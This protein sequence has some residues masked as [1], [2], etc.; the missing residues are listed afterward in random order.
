MGVRNNDFC[1][2][3]N[4]TKDSIQHMFWQCNHIKEFWQLLANMIN[5]KCSHASNIRISESLA[6]LGIDKDLHID[7]MFYLIILFAKQ[8]IYYCKL[9]NN[10]PVL[11]IFIKK[12]KKRY[13]IEE[14]IARKTF[15][16]NEF[17]TKWI[18]YKP[19]LD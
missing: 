16:Y 19:V 9:D 10:I 14:Y 15:T 12:L 17:I 2:F 6:L 18:L 5:E 13:E 3:C 8:Y 11:H 1:S 4:T 7:T